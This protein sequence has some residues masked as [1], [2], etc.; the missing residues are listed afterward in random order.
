MNIVISEA[1]DVHAQAVLG[2]LAKRRIRARLL[3]LSEFP[4]RASVS[5]R[6]QGGPGRFALR[7]ADRTTVD[8][9][10]VTGVW[11][12]RPQAFGLPHQGMDPQARHFAMVELATAFQGMWQ[13]SE[14][15]GST[16]SSGTPRPRTSRGN[17]SWPG[18]SASRF[19]RP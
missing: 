7:F 16:T 6:Y 5:M 2:D 4:L 15:S 1:N 11:W 10:D 19:R 18:R 12:R 9:A 14:R 17:S 13:A 3:D 8:M